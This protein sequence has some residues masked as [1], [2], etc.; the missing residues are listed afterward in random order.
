VAYFAPEW[1]AYFSPEWVA[2]FAPESWH[3]LVRII[4]L[5]PK[6]TVLI[7]HYQVFTGIFIFSNVIFYKFAPT[8]TF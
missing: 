5:P 6:E 7:V 2:Y 4:H 8:L 1:V 3:T